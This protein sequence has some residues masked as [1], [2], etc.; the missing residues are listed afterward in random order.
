MVFVIPCPSRKVLAPSTVNGRHFF[1][2]APCQPL[3]VKD[4]WGLYV[5]HH[6]ES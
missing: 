1:L 6:A 5:I 2:D 4:F 3:H